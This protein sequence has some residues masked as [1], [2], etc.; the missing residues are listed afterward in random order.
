MKKIVLF[1]FLTSIFVFIACD[2][3]TI[4]DP[5]DL[6]LCQS[7][8]DCL[9]PTQPFCDT[10]LN[11]CV[12]M[13]DCSAAAISRCDDGACPPDT[14]CLPNAATGLCQCEPE[15]VSKKVTVC[16]LGRWLRRL[17]GSS[18]RYVRTR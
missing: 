2:S 7:D 9:D 1:L 14:V 8:A 15:S 17:A 4:N 16:H 10:D 11:M 13:L 6:T 5:G 12:A 18:R 3:E